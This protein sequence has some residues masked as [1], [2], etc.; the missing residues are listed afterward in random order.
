[1]KN[2]IRIVAASALF[3]TFGLGLAALLSP[4]ARA[5]D[6]PCDPTFQMLNRCKAQHGRWD[7]T[8]CCCKLH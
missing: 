5:V 2:V 4:P 6:N 3:A 7:T 1:M 8:C